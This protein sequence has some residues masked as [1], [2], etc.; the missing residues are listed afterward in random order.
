MDQLTKM[1]YATAAREKNKGDSYK[2]MNKYIQA[3]SDYALT[4]SADNALML[5]SE[6][7]KEFNEIDSSERDMIKIGIIGEIYAKHNP[8]G[9]N[10]VANWLMEHGAEVIVPPLLPALVQGIINVHVNHKSFIAKSSAKTRFLSL[11]Y[12]QVFNRKIRESN[13]IINKLRYKVE[14]LHTIREIS[15]KAKKIISLNMQ[16]GDGWAIPGEIALLAEFNVKN[17]VCMQPFGCLATHILGKGMK[18]EISR[19][20]PDVNVLYI[21]V[22][23]GD[24]KVNILN[25]LHIFL[26]TA[27]SN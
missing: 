5:L 23:P 11:F 7:V 25:R 10:D 20:H 12:E 4:F 16:M 27:L 18:K 15:Q 17:I 19:I 8:F 21:D 13:K 26:Q 24:S 2:V 1:Y 9:N 3:V 6:A 22:D 14:P